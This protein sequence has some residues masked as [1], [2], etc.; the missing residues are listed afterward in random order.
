MNEAVCMYRVHMSGICAHLW[1]GVYIVCICLYG[2]HMM[3][4]CV[5]IH[6]NLCVLGKGMWIIQLETY[7][8]NIK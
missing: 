3:C 4:V 5:H 2:V 7:L 8:Q 1:G 6:M